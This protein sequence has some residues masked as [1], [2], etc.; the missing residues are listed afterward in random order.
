MKKLLTLAAL[1]MPVAMFAHG[2]HGM[3]NADSIL[4]YIGTPEHALP[5]TGVSLVAGWLLYRRYR[6][7]ESQ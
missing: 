1:L 6:K 5:I 7:M 2:G 3:F 4:H